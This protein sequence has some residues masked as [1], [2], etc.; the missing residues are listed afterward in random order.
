MCSGSTAHRDH[1]NS[2]ARETIRKTTSLLRPASSTIKAQVPALTPKPS[3]PPA[4]AFEISHLFL[5][6]HLSTLTSHQHH[7]HP[8][9]NPL[10]Q[11]SLVRDKDHCQLQLV[12]P[13]CP[14]APYP[15]L[16]GHPLT[17]PTLPP[18]PH[19]LPLACPT[20][21]TLTPSLH[22]SSPLLPPPLTP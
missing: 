9:T 2:P 14:P 22:T 5:P 6:G 3:L 18:A 15:S 13:H 19:R 17:C 11:H 20:T 21:R 4:P 16:L 7:P 12:S 10:A 8:S 1:S